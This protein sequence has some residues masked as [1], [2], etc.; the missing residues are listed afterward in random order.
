MTIYEKSGLIQP[1]GDVT[2]TSIGLYRPQ[3][4]GE[5]QALPLCRTQEQAEYALASRR[6]VVEY[7]REASGPFRIK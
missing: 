2:E 4:F 6:G 3:P 5:D 1:I 7:W